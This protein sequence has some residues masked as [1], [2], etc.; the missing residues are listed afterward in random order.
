LVGKPLANLLL[1]KGERGDATVTVCHSMTPNLASVCREAEIL[2][3]AVGKPGL[4]KGDMINPGA[5]VVDAGVNRTK[6]GIVGDVD[7]ESVARI[8]RAVTPVPGGV[9]P[10]TVAMLLA[11][12]IRAAEGCNNGN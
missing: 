5:V 12:T 3:V 8:A 7:F 1:M 4:I 6:D 11:N 9:G 10:M 2:I